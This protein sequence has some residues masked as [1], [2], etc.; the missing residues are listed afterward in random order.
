MAFARQYSILE[1]KNYLQLSEGR[2]RPWGGGAKPAGHA[3][4]L[5][6]DRASAATVRPGEK[7]HKPVDSGFQKAPGNRPHSDM[8]VSVTAAMNS[9]HGQL[10]LARLDAGADSCFIKAGIDYGGSIIGGRFGD[11]GIRVSYKGQVEVPKKLT[12][13]NV[14]IGRVGSITTDLHIQTAFPENM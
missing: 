13:M 2:P 10:E 1:V 9:S 14:Y 3:L 8:A 12:R 7:K 6:R 11:L 5:H 4:S